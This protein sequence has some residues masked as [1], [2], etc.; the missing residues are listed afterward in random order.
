MA[1]RATGLWVLGIRQVTAAEARGRRALGRRL[2]V[3]AAA[4]LL[5]L[6]LGAVALGLAAWRWNEGA[7]GRAVVADARHAALAV[8]AEIEARRTALRSFAAA[9]DG[10]RGLANLEAA[11]AAARR[12]A[13][14]LGGPVGVLD[15]SLGLLVDTSEP[16]GTPLGSTPAVAAGLW[17]LETGRARVSDVL[18]GPADTAS[19]PI[20]MLPLPRGGRAEAVLSL[21]IDTARLIAAIG[22]GP[23]A[24]LDGRGRVVASQGAS[25]AAALPDWPVLSALPR[26]EAHVVRGADG[27]DLR[28][29]LSY[30]S[31][32]PEWRL[33]VWRPAAT[34]LLPWMSLLPWL[35]GVILLSVLA[36]V[37]ALRRTR[38]ALLGP[39]GTL[40]HHAAAA[41]EAL[42]TDGIV[43]AVP[44][45]QSS[46]EFAALGA[47]LAEAQAA[48]QQRERRLRALA[49]AGAIVLWRADAGGGWTEAAGWAGLTGQTAP[50]FRGDGWI[51]M[52]HPDD[53]APT[54]AEWG[55][56]LVARSQIGV[57][58]RLRSAGE[59][60]GWRWVRATGVPIAN[61]DGPPLEW[62]GAIHDITDARGAGTAQRVNEAQVRQTVAELRAVYDTVPVGLA[63]VDAALRFVNVNARFAA[64]SGLPPEAH[65]ARAPHEVMPEG[66]ADPLE[67]AQR[68][69]LATGR[70]MLDVSCTG[71]A[72]GAVQHL[73]HWLASCHPVKD[74]AGAVTGVSA[75]LQ[76]VTDRVRAER[77]R[78]LL[79]TELNH[80]VKNTLAT[81]QSIA[82]Q[83]FRRAGAGAP[84]AARDFVGRLQALTRA[85]DL[86]AAEGWDRVD[87]LRVVRAGLQPWLEGGRAVRIGGSGRIQVDAGQAQALILALHE[88]AA[89]ATRHGALSRPG[90]EV[91]VAWSL[92]DD[93]VATF[94]WRESGGPQVTPPTPDR[95]GFGMRLLERGLAHDLGPGAEVRLTFPEDGMRAALR[96]RTGLPM[97]LPEPA[98]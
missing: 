14:T 11:D 77:S 60:G 74:A 6:A 80:R 93:G 42:R 57:E 65:I 97:L 58:F 40:A 82:A 43:P 12:L 41:A 98:A 64:I 32:A 17:A 96:F 51:E 62:V 2:L 13:E 50:A 61:D 81:V 37:V 54:L 15:R 91:E 30:L 89:N 71:Q 78:E 59:D 24:L 22:P 19:P 79:V 44:Q 52:L 56:A 84:G 70:P 39:I 75:V 33:V 55:R 18:P 87:L 9:L 27:R 4:G 73:R 23:A 53:R 25:S 63:L 1:G 21:R 48:G 67:K 46:G 94:D 38:D 10:G 35:G 31:E 28:L 26:G 86:M 16:F 90:G 85:H 3:V 88:L 68:E 47:A 92:G 95:R 72:P 20:L 49:E 76:D 45:P 66:L 29:A 7:T 36:A 8:D 83:S 69:V 5:P 34:G